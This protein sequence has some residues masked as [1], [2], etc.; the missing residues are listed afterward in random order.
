MRTPKFIVS[1]A[2]AIGVSTAVQALA[3]FRQILIA[4]YFGVSRELDVYVTAYTLAA[5]FVFTFANTFDFAVVPRL[6]QAR[7]EGGEERA[8]ALSAAMF[9][10]SL[11]LGIGATALLVA[12]T[13]LLTPLVATGF[14]PA[15][16]AHLWRLVV[17]FTPW[18]LLSLP[19]YAAAARQKSQRRFNRVFGAEIAVAVIS[20]AA[21]ILFHGRIE[22]L[23][24][25]YAVGYAAGLSTLLPASGLIGSAAAP[26]APLVLREVGELYAANQTG[27]LTSV[28]NRHF[29]SL[30]QPGGIA[31]VN[32]SAQIVTGLSTLLTFREIYIVPLSESERR[33]QKLERLVIGLLMLSVP[34]A[35]AV[36][37]FSHEMIQVLFQ[38]GRFDAAATDLTASVLR[39]YAFALI[40]AAISTPMMRMLQIVGRTRA[41]HVVYVVQGLVLIVFGAVLVTWA[42]FD[43]EGVAGMLLAAS[44]VTSAVAAGLVARYGVVVNWWRIGRYFGYAV[45]VT[46]VASACGTGVIAN[47][48]SPW[49]RLILG[50]AAYGTVVALTYFAVRRRLRTIAG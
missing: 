41:I 15:Q 18:A 2:S 10:W 22:L 34:A 37:C 31:A 40:P 38:R 25:A 43:A 6:V 50:G 30:V 9:R 19:Y 16:Q 47:A 3:F 24:I 49:S 33:E 44:V 7:G 39:I 21:L 12:L 20:I 13:P 5:M 29:Q 27:A 35:G 8:S 14:G 32:Y 45:I 1:A 11:A 46:V 26:E 48:T 17:W 36:A 23:P 42:R 28:V 4:S